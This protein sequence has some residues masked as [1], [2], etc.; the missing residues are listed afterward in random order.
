MA[1]V[2]C[3]HAVSADWNHPIAVRPEILRRQLRALARWGWKPAAASDVI[4]RR[5]RAL[6]VT[7]DDAYRSVVA[8]LPVLEQFGLRPTVFACTDG[9]T[10]RC[11]GELEIAATG[12]ITPALKARIAGGMNLPGMGVRV[13]LV[14]LFGAR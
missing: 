11:I 13:G 10:A 12:V 9:P 3:Y 4:A 6:H 7:F 8:A 2:L 5:S 1:L 14:Y